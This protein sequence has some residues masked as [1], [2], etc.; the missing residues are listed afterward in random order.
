[1]SENLA[2]RCIFKIE[3]DFVWIAGERLLSLGG[4]NL[5]DRW[6]R[7]GY[8]REVGRRGGGGRFRLSRERRFGLVFFVVLG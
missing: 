7:G 1:M 8:R 6:R 4:F 5:V 3:S 2:Q